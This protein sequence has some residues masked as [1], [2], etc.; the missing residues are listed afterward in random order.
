[1]P[2]L[3]LVAPLARAVEPPLDAAQTRAADAVAAGTGNL[4]I[5]GVPGSGKTAVAVAGAARAVAAGLAPERVLVIAP[6][7]VAAALLRDRVSAAM[8]RPTGSP[9][10]RTAASAAYA[11]LAARARVDE[12]PPPALV[13]GAEQDVILRELLAGHAAGEGARVDWASAVPLEATALAGFREELRNL[14]MRAAESGLG[15]GDM[16][17]LARLTQRPEWLAAAQVYEEYDNVMALRGSPGDQ[18]ARYDPA[19]VVSYAADVLEQWDEVLDGPRPGWDLVIVDDF[20][21]ATS[22]TGRLLQVAAAN[23]ARIAVLGNSDESVQGYRGAMPGALGAAARPLGEGGFDAEVL[24][25]TEQYRQHP[26]LAALTQRVADRIG[27]PAG[28]AIRMM[29][30]PE[31]NPA[32]APQS[33]AD[34]HPDGA[35]GDENDSAET[36]SGESADD[37]ESRVRVMVAPHRYSQSRAIAAQLRRARHGFDGDSSPWGQMVVIAR[38]G[39]QLRELRSD[40]IAADIPCETVGDALALHREPAVAALLSVVRLALGEEWTEDTALELLG[41]RLIGLDAIG[42]RRLRRA[43]VRANREEGGV[44]TG[45]E[46]VIAALESPELLSALGEPEARRARIAALAVEVG[47]AAASAP[48]ATPG[49]VL[50]AV[51]DSL[52]VSDAWRDAALAGSS[53]DDADLDAVI[54]LMRAAQ[55]FSERMPEARIGQFLEYLEAQDFAADSLGAR[56]VGV[57]VV[58]FATPASAAGREWDVVVV[59]GLDEGVWPNLKLRDSVLGAAHFAD[60]VAGRADAI[61]LTAESRVVAAHSARKAVLDDETRALLVAV[62]R[63]RQR[64]VVACLEGDESRPSRFVSIIE[65][66]TGVKRIDATELGR[67]ADL[68]AAVATLRTEAQAASADDRIAYARMLANLALLDLPGAHPARWN[69]VP[70]PS[71][72]LPFW[73]DD[74]V[75]RVSPSRVDAVERCALKW[76][77]ESAGGSKEST[78]AQDLGTLIHEI[79]AALPSGTETELFAEFERRWPDVGGL[80]TWAQRVDYQRARAMIKKLAAYIVGSVPH[81]LFVEKDFAVTLG[82]ARLAGQADRVEISDGKARIVDLKTGTAIPKGEVVDHGQ[83]A[84][85][86]LAANHGAFEGV[87]EARDASLVFVGDASRVSVNELIQPAVDDAATRARLD[88]VVHIMTGA[89]FDATTN[90]MCDHCPVRRSCPARPTGKQVSEL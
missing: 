6:T 38:S 87:S 90:S 51:W 64:L 36:D 47:R 75:V 8:G 10:V 11:L 28:S 74:A 73:D 35:G 59:A 78:Q 89:S 5:V 16:A 82:R 1:M 52:G 55:T 30:G 54:A 66:A 61:P 41:S 48:R 25:L 63:A 12:M 2:S 17:E 50:W 43:L 58:S 85:Y 60:I 84:M 4:A 3:A 81:E 69:G 21:D 79:A 9:V 42:I 40:L 57:D 26:A 71:T 62:S 39:A 56:A 67:V 13:T 15:P 86:Q 72:D 45:A 68:R 80:E 65:E 14:L 18:G 88:T 46:L 27:M 29:P 70:E 31:R 7:R 23:G 53:R 37:V 76:A 34:I 77:L 32:D 83:L 49:G 33:S 44:A 20:H 24:T 22:A 19:A